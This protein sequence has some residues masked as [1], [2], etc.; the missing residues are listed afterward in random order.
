MRPIF[1]LC[2]ALLTCRASAQ[3]SWTEKETRLAN[4]YLSLLVEQPEYGR[5][6]DMLWDLYARHDSTPLLLKNIQTQAAQTE[7]TSV[8][9]IHA[10]LLRKSGALPAAAALYDAVLKVQADHPIAL[11]ARAELAQKLN[12][13]PLAM[14]LLR[15]A[16][17]SLADQ[18]A[19]K[20]AAYM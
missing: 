16:A 2:L 18:D 17:E 10:H 11:R 1:F 13:L 9:L 5:V 4:E 7:H 8:R 6:L 20:P 14:S 3:T 19:G 15:R 12:D